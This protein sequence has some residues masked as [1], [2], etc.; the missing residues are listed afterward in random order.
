MFFLF[1]SNS[2][3]S[4]HTISP[5]NSIR[6]AIVMQR[7]IQTITEVLKDSYNMCCY[8]GI[9]STKQ[10]EAKLHGA[11]QQGDESQVTK[12]TSHAFFGI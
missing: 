8:L 7:V 5:T 11:P 2:E 4:N 6:V 3:N 10:T 9:D 12:I 1:K